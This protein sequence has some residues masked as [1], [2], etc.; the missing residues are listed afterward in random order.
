MIQQLRFCRNGSHESWEMYESDKL[1]LFVNATEIHVLGEGDD[2]AEW[3]RAWK[4][5]LPCDQHNVLIIDGRH[6]YET[7][8]PNITLKYDEYSEDEVRIY[9][10]GKQMPN[11]NPY[12]FD[13]NDYGV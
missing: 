3:S 6:N 12:P 1:R 9:D 7:F 11:R 8:L 4:F 5:P 2:I 10:E 13:T